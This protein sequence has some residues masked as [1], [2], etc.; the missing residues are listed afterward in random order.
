MHAP[1]TRA[2]RLWLKK[3]GNPCRSGLDIWATDDVDAHLWALAVLDINPDFKLDSIERIDWFDMADEPDRKAAIGE[4]FRLIG[5]DTKA[6]LEGNDQAAFH[7]LV[8]LVIALE[9]CYPGTMRELRMEGFE[10]DTG[11]AQK[12]WP[13]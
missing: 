11:E 8:H 13:G 12:T 7:D 2:Y 4:M 9:R 6:A 3:D 1:F 5:A 10:L